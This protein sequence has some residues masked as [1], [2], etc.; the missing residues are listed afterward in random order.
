MTD[1]F[2]PQEVMKAVDA[3]STAVKEGNE[4]TIKKATDFLA[5]Q[6]AKNQKITT[7]LIKSNEAIENLENSIRNYRGFSYVANF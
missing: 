3:L 5:V 2:N 6:D 4:A 7:D 1:N